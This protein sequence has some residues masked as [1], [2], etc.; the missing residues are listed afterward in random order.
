[1]KEFSP[2]RARSAKGFTLIEIMIVVIIIGILSAVAIPQVTRFIGQGKTNAAQEEYHAV[3]SAVSA[4]MADA[5]VS[6]ISGADPVPVNSSS[7]VNFTSGAATITGTTLNIG[8]FFT[9]GAGSIK[10]TYAIGTDGSVF[11]KTTGS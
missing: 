8:Q 11:Q 4:A 5:Q 10:G 1:M 7:T 3:V 9:S 2:R 6:T